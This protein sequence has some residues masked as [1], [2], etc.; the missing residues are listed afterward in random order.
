MPEPPAST[1]TRAAPLLANPGEWSLFVDIDGTLLG[2][3]PTPDAVTVPRGLVA[4][5]DSI[6]RGLGG[7]V[8]FITG[9][10]VADADRLFAP[11]KLVSAGVHGTEV[12]QAI[13]G[14]IELLAPPVSST[15]VEAITEVTALAPGILVE[16]KGA[17]LAVHYRKAPLVR[18]A[19]VAELKRI[20]AN[21]A[22]PLTLRNGRMVIEVVPKG[23]SKGTA[24]AWLCRLDDFKGRRPIMIGDDV[25]DESALQMA[26]RLGGM[27]LSVAG[28][29]FSRRVAHFDDVESVRA[30][31]G[32]LA[33][34]LERQDR[35]VAGNVP[36][37]RSL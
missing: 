37:H 11:L 32:K 23:F 26:E 10:R 25:G 8:C 17:G 35:L 28:E 13:G 31:L 33:R 27:G 22:E 30:W 21:A 6:V 7:A 9:R 1:E 34:R 18:P 14:P 5:L 4:T 16:Q 2:M 15:M 12:R 19:L 36:Y 20:V 29:H 3:A 24:L